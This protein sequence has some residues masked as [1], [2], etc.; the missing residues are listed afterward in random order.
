MKKSKI[1]IQVCGAQNSGK[2][3]IITII[4][5]ALQSEGLDLVLTPYTTPDGVFLEEII[6]KDEILSRNIESIK[7]KTAIVIYE[8]NMITFPNKRVE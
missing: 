2:S 4:R 5:N 6:V 8:H 3:T 1:S 7:E